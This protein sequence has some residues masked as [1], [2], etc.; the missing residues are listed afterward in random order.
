MS[1]LFPRYT[2]DWKS[3]MLNC[4]ILLSI[5]VYLDVPADNSRSKWRKRERERERE[6]E[7]AADEVVES[8]V[9][10]ERGGE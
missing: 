2:G 7:D 3:L 6:R 4:V 10:V 5:M 1:V 8:E 9:A